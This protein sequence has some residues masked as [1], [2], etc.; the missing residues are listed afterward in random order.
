MS[1][2][3]AHTELKGHRG[4]V[5]CFAGFAAT[6]SNTEAAVKSAESEENDADKTTTGQPS[7]RLLASGSDDKTVRIWDT[8]TNKPVK[9]LHGCFPD[10]IE[11][12]A[13]VP[14]DDNLLFAASGNV[15]YSFD[16]RQPS[17]IQNTALSALS[18]I[19]ED[20][21]TLDV[22]PN[23]RLLAVS[24]DS[25][26]IYFVPFDEQGALINSKETGIRYKTLSRVHNNIVGSLKFHVNPKKNEVI[27]GGFDC[28][29]CIWDLDRG[30]PVKSIQFQCLEEV[31]STNQVFNPPFVHSLG[32]ICEGKLIV[33]GLGDGSVSCIRGYFLNFSYLF[34]IAY[35]HYSS[36][37]RTQRI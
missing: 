13:F 14:T 15:L 28:M 35:L 11:G 25:N 26:N 19:F 21:N 22:H 31:A 32:Y 29:A 4:P 17:V 1:H 34:L 2:L 20:I 8:R 5:T 23:Q 3:I 10:S 7:R 30:R 36:E 27:S 24:D 9:C 16:L 12:V 18:D 6:S 33:S 37:Y